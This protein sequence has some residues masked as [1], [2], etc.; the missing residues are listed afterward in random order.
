MT[1]SGIRPRVILITYVWSVMMA[2]V[3]LGLAGLFSFIFVSEAEKT[4]PS[5]LQLFRWAVVCFVLILAVGHAVMPVLPRRK[6]VW[7]YG[8]VL[9]GLSCTSLLTAPAAVPI[10][11]FWVKPAVREYFNVSSHATGVPPTAGA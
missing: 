4:V 6:P 11:I 1:A 5:S 9:L 3:Y 2:L 7:V 8:I 10:L